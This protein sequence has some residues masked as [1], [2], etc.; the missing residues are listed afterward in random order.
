MQHVM[1]HFICADRGATAIEYG[2]ISALIVIAIIGGV[3]AVG[4]GVANSLYNNLVS[5]FN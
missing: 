2:M 4:A 1:H 5:A 3:Q